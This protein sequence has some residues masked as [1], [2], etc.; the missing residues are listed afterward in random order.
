MTIDY[1]TGPQ[2]A[3]LLGV[4]PATVRHAIRDGRLRATK[5]GRDWYIRRE[6]V[7]RYNR[8]RQNSGKPFRAPRGGA[9][10]GP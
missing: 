1:L 8:E 4:Q 7:E 2:A 3:A 6:E 9:P 10:D 5:R